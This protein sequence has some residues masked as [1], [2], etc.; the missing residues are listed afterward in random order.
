MIDGGIEDDLLTLFSHDGKTR[1]CHA[2]VQVGQYEYSFGP[3]GVYL[4]E[5]EPSSELLAFKCPL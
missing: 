4:V 5:A 2:A 3:L 1:L